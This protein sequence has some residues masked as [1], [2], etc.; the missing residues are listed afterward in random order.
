MSGEEARRLAWELGTLRRRRS[1][2]KL[3]WRRSRVDLSCSRSPPG[4]ASSKWR[5]PQPLTSSTPNPAFQLPR[6]TN[7]SI[8]AAP[9]LPPPPSSLAPS[10]PISLPSL[11]PLP[12]LS[13]SSP[14][15]ALPSSYSDL[16][17][18]PLLFPLPLHPLRPLPPAT[19]LILSPPSS[20]SPPLPLP[21]LLGVTLP[22]PTPFLPPANLPAHR[23]SLEPHPRLRKPQTLP[24]SPSVPPPLDS[25]L[26]PS[27]SPPSLPMVPPPFLSI[28]PPP[29]SSSPRDTGRGQG[30]VSDPGTSISAVGTRSECGP[31]A[32]GWAGRVARC[33]MCMG[34]VW[35]LRG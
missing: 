10:F 24:S 21:P 26:L 35:L 34:F 30:V 17:R 9:L 14:P 23:A 29:P 27:S 19:R 6:P 7:V 18:P 33:C 5:R 25:S 22:S 31:R 28:R 2:L 16:L 13:S 11:P 20:P 1:P 4:P 32:P 12:R 8:S 3:G 15:L